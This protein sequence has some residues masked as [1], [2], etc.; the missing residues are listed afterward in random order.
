LF[1]NLLHFDWGHL[2]FDHTE[3]YSC[4]VISIWLLICRLKIQMCYQQQPR[5]VVLKL[6]WAVAR[7]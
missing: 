4:F 2:S 7:I 5:A 6:S 3:M 1:E